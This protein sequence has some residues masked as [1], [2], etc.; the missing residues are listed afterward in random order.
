[1]QRRHWSTASRNYAGKRPD[2][3]PPN[4]TGPWCICTGRTTNARVSR[5]H[6]RTA[7]ASR[8]S[9]DSRWARPCRRHWPPPSCSPRAGMARVT[10]HQSHVRQRHASR[11]RAALIGLD[12]APGLLR[13]NFGFMHLKA[14]TIR[15]GTSSARRRGRKRKK[16]LR[17][18]IIATDIKPAC[19][20]CIEEERD[21]SRR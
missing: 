10:F 11:S 13:G 2:S 1:M 15:S 9:E 21:Y 4:A 18:K 3:R 19:G 20:R 7:V 17:G 5:H 14:S 8:L 12:R 6:G 16:S